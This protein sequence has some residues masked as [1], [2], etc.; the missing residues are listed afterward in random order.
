MTENPATLSIRRVPQRRILPKS[1][2]PGKLHRKHTVNKLGSHT[3]PDFRAAVKEIADADLAAIADARGMI[4]LTTGTNVKNLAIHS[5]RDGRP[6]S[7]H[8][9]ENL[10]PR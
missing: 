5:K 10:S 4:G 6:P 9:P 1:N 7:N 3:P 8:C 2:P